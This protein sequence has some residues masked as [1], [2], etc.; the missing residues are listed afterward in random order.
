MLANRVVNAVA[1][2]L[3]PLTDPAQYVTTA[4]GGC[5]VT[6]TFGL[7]LWPLG[8]LWIVLF[9]GPLLAMSWLWDRAPLL[10]LP[11]GI[12]GV[13]AAILGG[14]YVGLMPARGEFASRPIKLLICWTWPFSLDYLQYQRG[15][16]LDDERLMRI[17]GILEWHRETEALASRQTPQE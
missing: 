13:P 1:G 16:D 6:L 7:L 10:R 2:A 5:L 4:V 9:L 17:Q 15:E 3:R 12:L 14:I 8:L 11:L